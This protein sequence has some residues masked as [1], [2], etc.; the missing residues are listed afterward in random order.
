MTI[1]PVRI[2]LAEDHT[3]VRAGIRALL[4]SLPGVEVIAEAGDGREAL[5]L[6]EIHRPD[7][8]FMDIAMSGMNG[9]EATTR[10][11]RDLPQVRVMILSMHANEE[12]VLQALRAGASGYLLKDAGT[13]ELEVAVAAVARGETYLSPA[14]S[15]QVIEDYV[16]RVGGGQGGESPFDRLTP[17]QREILQLI[18]EGRTT[19]DIARVLNISLKTAETHRAQLME[20]LDIYD[21]PGLVRYAIRIGLVSPDH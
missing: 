18:A 15:K 17:R 6:A 3:L 9:L 1:R 14:I 5:R 10:I 16:R 19:Q 2:L 11:A 20:R 7:I 8:V 12:Y 4:Q 21:V 13:A